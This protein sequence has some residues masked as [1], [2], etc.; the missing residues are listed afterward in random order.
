MQALPVPSRGLGGRSR[1]DP[2]WSRPPPLVDTSG[3]LP[4]PHAAS[5][6]RQATSPNARIVRAVSH[7]TC[8]IVALEIVGGRDGVLEDGP[9][10]RLALGAEGVRAVGRR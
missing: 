2:G 10:V 1:A 3:P 9:R 7:M 4:L 5:G 6:G 8:L